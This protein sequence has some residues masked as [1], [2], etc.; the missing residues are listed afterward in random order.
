[1]ERH[2]LL[3]RRRSDSPNH[4][5]LLCL[6]SAR[7]SV[8]SVWANRYSC[9]CRPDASARFRTNRAGLSESRRCTGKPLPAPA[10]TCKGFPAQWQTAF[11]TSF[12]SHPPIGLSSAQQANPDSPSRAPHPLRRTDYAGGSPRLRYTT[13]R[14]RHPAWRRRGGVAA[15]RTTGNYSGMPPLRSPSWTRANSCR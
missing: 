2:T 8:S 3:H 11:A 1:M 13:A 5:A 6:P 12:E 14:F 15:R 10:L 4:R 9:D 7:R